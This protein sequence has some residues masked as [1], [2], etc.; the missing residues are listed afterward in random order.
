[1]VRDATVGDARGIAEVQ[2]AAWRAAY[3]G[4]LPGR[5]LD[6]LSVGLREDFWLSHLHGRD[7]PGFTLVAEE[8][9]SVAGFCSLV[10]PSRDEGAGDRTAEIVATYVDPGR[11]G[12]GVGRELL[13]RARDRLLGGDW[14]DVTLWVFMRNAHGR[15]F[16]A[17]SGF[18]LDGT[19][20]A[21]EPSGVS[22]VRMRL[23]LT[24]SPT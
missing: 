16:Y 21:H 23:A 14:D 7:H 4:I 20:G 11:W 1:M 24:P 6:D 9:G 10:L 17:R 13:G 15:A 2:V 18:R 3:R 12:Q 19:K 5:L 22:T 8:A